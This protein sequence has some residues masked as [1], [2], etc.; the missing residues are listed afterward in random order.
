VACSPVTWY[1]SFGLVADTPRGREVVTAYGNEA[2][3]KGLLSQ[4]VRNKTAVSLYGKRRLDA[5]SPEW[6][7]L[8]SGL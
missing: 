8:T 1:G 2:Q 5:C 3:V 6:V 7:W 4:A